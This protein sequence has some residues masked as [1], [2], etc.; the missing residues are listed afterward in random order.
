MF[1]SYLWSV[2]KKNLLSVHSLVLVEFGNVLLILLSFLKIDL[3][4]HTEV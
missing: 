4:V 3:I 1:S 2:C